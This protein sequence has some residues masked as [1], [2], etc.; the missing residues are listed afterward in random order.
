MKHMVIV[1][2]IMQS[3]HV[4]VSSISPPCSQN[5]FYH[6]PFKM[7]IYAFVILVCFEPHQ[8]WLRC[9]LPWTLI[10]P[11]LSI[12][13][14][15]SSS[16]VGGNLCSVGN[17]RDFFW[18]SLILLTTCPA[19]CS[20]IELIVYERSQL[21][22][23]LFEPKNPSCDSD[24]LWD[25]PVV[26]ARL[27]SWRCY[28]WQWS[29]FLPFPEFDSTIYCFQ[30]HSSPIHVCRTNPQCSA[31]LQYFI[32][33]LRCSDLACWVF[34]SG[35]MSTYMLVCDLLNFSDSVAHELILA[36]N[37]FMK[38]SI[39][40]CLKAI[41][42]DVWRLLV[43][44]FQNTAT[45]SNSRHAISSSHARVISLCGATLQLVLFSPA[46]G[47]QAAAPYDTGLSSGKM[48]RQSVLLQFVCDL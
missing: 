44:G 5:G 1:N 24:E 33:Q 16:W 20:F 46:R 47:G 23:L 43:E 18:E 45:Q 36:V 3:W 10:M 6:K 37:I 48:W 19:L 15:H 41:G 11:V 25:F 8:S 27:C 42:V 35:I 32:G 38:P 14:E 17:T 9:G 22:A 13:S 26:H 12:I 31:S 2:V 4:P 7:P 40:R 34:F 21:A 30:N 39:G 29:R 28:R